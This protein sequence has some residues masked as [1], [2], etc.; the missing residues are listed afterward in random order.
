MAALAKVAQKLFGSGGAASGFGEFGSFAGGSPT[1]TKDPTL[2][3]ANGAFIAGWLAAILANDNPAIEDMNSLFLL[4]FYQI[5]YSWQAGIPEWDT[6]TEY[7]IGSLV[8]VGGKVYVSATALNTG[9][10]VTD[11]VNWYLQDSKTV[12]TA[13]A[14]YTFGDEDIVRSTNAA[15]TIKLPLVAGVAL[16]TEKVVVGVGAST[17]VDGNGATI[18]GFSTVTLTNT[19]GGPLQRESI[20]VKLTTSTAWELV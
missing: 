5:A 4:A 16:G 19:G 6:V 12:T 18:N 8:N 13:L 20:R 2:I 1:N 9:N 17:V 7:K 3:Q 14:S 10:L 11:K 15:A